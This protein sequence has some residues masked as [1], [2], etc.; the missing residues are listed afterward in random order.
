MVPRQQQACSRAIGSRGCAQGPAS[1][2]RAGDASIHTHVAVTKD[3]CIADGC[4][5]IMVGTC[6]MSKKLLSR[7][8]NWTAQRA[9][10]WSTHLFGAGTPMHVCAKKGGR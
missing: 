3:V 7:C 9:A 8:S 4:M 5:L 2:A 1:R 10:R 6:A